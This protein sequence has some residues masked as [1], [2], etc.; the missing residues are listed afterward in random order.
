M[1]A[2]ASVENLSAYLANSLTQKDL[3]IG[4]LIL[5]TTILRYSLSA[6]ILLIPSNVEP[7]Y[8]SKANMVLFKIYSILPDQASAPQI[9]LKTPSKPEA[10]KCLNS[11]GT[12]SM[13]LKAIGN[14][15][16]PGSK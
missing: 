15:R 3:T 13:T 10:T 5:A 1:A 7:G 2:V 12:C 6:N 11:K 14:S 4:S 16:S 8:S 9:F